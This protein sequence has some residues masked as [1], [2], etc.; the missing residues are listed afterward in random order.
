[1]VKEGLENLKSAFFFPGAN[2]SLHVQKI[3]QSQV[4]AT[5]YKYGVLNSAQFQE[6]FWFIPQ[7][8]FLPSHHFCYVFLLC[9]DFSSF[10]IELNLL[11]ITLKALQN[12]VPLLVSYTITLYII[13]NIFHASFNFFSIPNFTS[14]SCYLLFFEQY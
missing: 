12:P 2:S 13:L 11:F 10:H 5:K 9:T 3:Y 14:I 4:L 7:K 6:W 1:M 8:I